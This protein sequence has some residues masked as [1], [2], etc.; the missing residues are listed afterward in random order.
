MEKLT[1]LLDVQKIDNELDQL[2]YRHEHLPERALLAELAEQ[3]ATLDAAA[4]KTEAERDGLRTQQ[5]QIENEAGDIEEKAGTLD[6]K[7]YDGSVTSPKEA[8]ALGE[9]IASLKAQQSEK[10]DAAIE[11]LMEIEPLD[12]QLVQAEAARGELDAKQAELQSALDADVAD[13]DAQIAAAEA[14]RAEAASKLDE[15]TITQYGKLRITYGPDAVIQFDAGKGGGCPV[16]MSA[17]ELDRWKH[18]PAGTLEP[19]TD[20]GRLVAKLD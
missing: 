15:A 16:A 11:L 2:R 18:L 14:N 3:R 5:R 6:A 13:L 19:C 9:E 7:L 10:E 17:V 20:C 1:V 8:S 12:E 4:A